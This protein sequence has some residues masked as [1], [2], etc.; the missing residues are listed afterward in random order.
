MKIIK[1]E[2]LPEFLPDY[3]VLITLIECAEAE[4]KAKEEHENKNVITCSET[5]RKA[6]K[7]NQDARCK[8]GL[9]RTGRVA[10]CAYCGK[11]YVVSGTTQKYCSPKCR[12]GQ[13]NRNKRNNART[14]ATTCIICGKG[15][16]TSPNTKAKTCGKDCLLKY[17]S[18]L[19]V[20]RYKAQ[21]AQGAMNAWNEYMMP[22]PWDTHKL[23]TL[24]PGVTSWSDP[25]MDPLSG[26]F[27]M[28]TFSVPSAALEV[29][30]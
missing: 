20:E 18:D 8:A 27:P 5:C 25:I 11:K 12:K 3:F 13:D 9:G 17:R 21:K 24:P 10:K 6:R 26:G 2:V 4:R 7:R 23:A 30:A 1:P 14:L 22:C 29:A 19:T 16:M 28:R 15:F